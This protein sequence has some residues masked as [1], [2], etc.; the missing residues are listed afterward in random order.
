MWLIL[1]SILICG[2]TPALGPQGGIDSL[3]SSPLRQH[4]ATPASPLLSYGLALTAQHLIGHKTKQR[5][6]RAVFWVT[7][8]INTAF[9][10]RLLSPWGAG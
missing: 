6:L 4:E 2:I 1:L 3:R 5:E 7:V 8:E 9:V 10:A